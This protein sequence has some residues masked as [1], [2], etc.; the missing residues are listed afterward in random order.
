MGRMKTAVMAGVA[1]CV[2]CATAQAGGVLHYPGE[3]YAAGMQCL[4]GNGAE[5]NPY[6]AMQMF[7]K[8]AARGS[9]EAEKAIGL[10]YLRGIG[11][12]EDAGEG[13]RWLRQAA[14]HGDI[15]AQVIYADLC[16]NGT[17][18]DLDITQAYM[19]YKVVV[20]RGEHKAVDSLRWVSREM[21][22]DDI[23][24]AEEMAREQLEYR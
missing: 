20:T 8:A 5:Q 3:L 16:L 10:M 7:E 2:L 14:E 18:V 19:W 13:A 21:S 11:V 23:R 12:E 4:T 22:E 9:A 24:K 1:T 15:E 6:R 17:G